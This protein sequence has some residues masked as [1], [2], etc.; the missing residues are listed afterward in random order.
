MSYISRDVLTD[1]QKRYIKVKRLFDICFSLLLLLLLWPLMLLAALWVKMESSGPVIYSQRR[2]GYHQKIFSIYKFRSMRVETTRNGVPLS[3]NER[4]TRSG[5]IL[6]KTSIDELPQ[7]FN[8]LKGEMSLIGPRPQ[9]INDLE[10]FTEDQLIRFEVLPGI[11]SWTAIHG[12]NMI[13]VQEKYNLDVYYVQHIGFR[14][15]A[16]IFFKTIPLVLSQKDTVDLINEQIP[17]SEILSDQGE[18]ETAV[19]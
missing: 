18:R 14:I 10:T 16:E 15:D 12:R 19:K 6:R 1:G 3:D 5:N 9:L 7:L 8:I 2:P 13:D 11:T 17:A 4:I